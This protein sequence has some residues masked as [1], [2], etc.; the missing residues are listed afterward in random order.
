M[1]LN[2]KIL[3]V[4]TEL[5]E[6]TRRTEDIIEL[7]G[8]H[9][10]GQPERFQEKVKRIFKYAQV[11]QR[12]SI[13]PEERVFA[14]LSFE[15]KNDYYIEKVIDLSEK[16]LRKTLL[17]ANLQPDDIDFII[18]VSCT[19]FMIPSVDAFLINKLRMRQDI[20]RLPV[21][22]M[23]CA[24]G[25]SALIY[26]DNF[27]RN[28][29]GSRAAIIAVESP[30]STFQHEDFS[31]TNM[32][33]SAIFGDGAACAILGYDEK[34]G[35]AIIDTEMFHFYDEIQ[36]MGFRV[37]N[38]GFQ[39]VLDP[40]VPEKIQDH[41]DEIIHPFLAKNNL[42]IEDIRHL[43]FHPGGKKIVQLV[44]ELF[45]KLGKNIDATRA[46]LR[47][48]GNM[49]SATVLYVLKSIM[50]QETAVGEKGLMLSFGPGFSAQR[51]L[52]EW[53]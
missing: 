6:Y 8:E 14:P 29:P 22:E 17:K 51:V 16:V 20:V 44:D 35:P 21:T 2:P 32:V 46:I 43:I 18:T 34:P 45:G 36:M 10:K 30:M 11:D 39:M 38:S 47:D 26:A 24:A 40:G 9:L 23:G 48:Y 12:Y 7:I 4:E 5:P 27:V 33:S 28:K 42:T 50:E 13:M 1:P 15:E 49:S 3:A 25:V 41:F 52:L 31:M 37:R 19:G 53:Q